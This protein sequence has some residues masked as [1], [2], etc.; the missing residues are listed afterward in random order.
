MSSCAY[1]NQYHICTPQNESLAIPLSLFQDDGITPISITSWSFTGSVKYDFTEQTPITN[2]TISI[3][4]VASGSITIRLGAE[5]MWSLTGSRYVY[6]VI[7]NNPATP[8]ETYRLLYGRFKVNSGVT[9][10]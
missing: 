8:P 1:S 9:E 4:S 3:N 10:P 2:F 5:S 7:A 6:D